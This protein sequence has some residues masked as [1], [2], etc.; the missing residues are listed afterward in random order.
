MRCPQCELTL[1]DAWRCAGG[2]AFS[3]V[4][5]VR[6]LISPEFARM[7]DPFLQAFAQYR[8][9]REER[10]P[11]PALFP[12]LPEAGIDLDPGLWR[13]RVLDLQLVQGHIGARQG[14]RVLD[15][16]A[17][18][19]WLSHRLAAAGH[20]VTAVDVFTDPLD[21]LGAVVHYPANFRAIQCDQERLHLLDGPYDLIVAQRC[22]GYMVDIAKSIEQIRGLLAPGGSAILT[23]LNIFRRTGPIRAHFAQSAT[24]F[25]EQFG[26]PY[27]FKPVKGY[28]D[29]DD[30]YQLVTCGVELVDQPGSGMT[31]LL[32]RPFP[33]K[34]VYR[35]GSFRK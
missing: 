27:F 20:L 28:L 7:L 24:R 1:D 4:Q 32:S 12:R 6:R 26:I 33:W 5:G 17:W 11:E 34:P 21:G 15:V 10:M 19:G 2:H 14:L 22:M 9:E 31:N 16:G 18:N 30:Q 8:H 25:Q 35:Y 13:L 29:L 3:E 23:G